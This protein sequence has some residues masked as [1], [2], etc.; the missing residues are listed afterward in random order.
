MLERSHS[1]ERAD[2][3]NS[4]G[5]QTAVSNSMKDTDSAL[6]EVLPVAGGID[7]LGET[8]SLQVSS[9]PQDRLVCFNDEESPAAESFRLLGV[10]LRH[11]RREKS[12]KKVLITSTIPAEGK[13]MVAANIACTL[14][15][16]TPQKTLLLEGDLRRPSLSRMFGLGKNPGLCEYL[17]DE[18][19]VTRSIYS[20]KGKGLWLLPAGSAQGNPLELLQSARLPAL[21]EQLTAWFEWIIID[22]PPVLPLADTS[23]WARWADGILLV[24]RQG[25][26]QKRQLQRGIE[27]IE[28]KKLIGAI[29]NSSTNSD[30]GDYYYRPHAA[31]PKGDALTGNI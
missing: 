28:S 25:T 24:I 14:A 22:S 20:L 10:R 13:S 16:R 4:I 7:D 2:P 26:T 6:A 21:M 27:A 23:V 11:L 30:H 5:L 1:T 8:E 17:R 18:S 15:L 9:D 3:S 29:L 12:L 19:S 31:S